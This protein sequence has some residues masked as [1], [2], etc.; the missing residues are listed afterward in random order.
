MC[1]WWL[2]SMICVIIWFGLQFLHAH[3]I[4]SAENGEMRTRLHAQCIV[5]WEVD[6]LYIR[7]FFV[8]FA[9]KLVLYFSRDLS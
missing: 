1:A 5:I 8:Q 4:N 3:T 2:K 9:L 7:L 6:G